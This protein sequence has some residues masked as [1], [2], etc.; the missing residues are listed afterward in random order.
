MNG[1]GGG[2]LPVT[3]LVL[4]VFGYQFGLSE[5]VV[6][7]AVMLIASVAVYRLATRDAR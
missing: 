2:G 6:A 4:T 3:G 7:L 5:I 1:Y